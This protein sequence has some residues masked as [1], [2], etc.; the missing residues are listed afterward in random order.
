[1]QS[2]HDRAMT[3]HAA[4]LHGAIAATQ[5]TFNMVW[6]A[7]TALAERRPERFAA[8]QKG[9]PERRGPRPPRADA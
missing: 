2:S 4:R 5:T 6:I 9:L 8:R 1:M 3:E 7:T